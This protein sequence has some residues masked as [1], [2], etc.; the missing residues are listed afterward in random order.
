MCM[1]LL[2]RM[3]MMMISKQIMGVPV[4][5]KQWRPKS[6]LILRIYVI[7]GWNDNDDDDDDDDN[8][9]NDKDLR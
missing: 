9:D 7:I 6:R 5:G 3:V 8:D 1:L 2:G 4:Y